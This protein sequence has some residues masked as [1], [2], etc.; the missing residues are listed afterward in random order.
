MTTTIRGLEKRTFDAPDEIR[1]PFEKG[2]I[3]VVTLAGLTF[4]KGDATAGVAMVRAR[5]AGGRHREL[6]ALPPQGD[7]FWTAARGDGRRRRARL[8]TR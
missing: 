1:I 8:E 2:R 3:D 5:Q 4:Y 6:T 7:P